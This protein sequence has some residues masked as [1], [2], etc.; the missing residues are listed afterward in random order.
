M[1]TTNPADCSFKETLCNFFM[2]IKLLGNHYFAW[3]TRS[4]EN[5]D[6]SISIWW[7]QPETAL[8]TLP[9]APRACLLLEVSRD[10]GAERDSFH[11]VG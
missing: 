3:L 7:Q 10:T 8:A 9:V 1:T 4:D 11:I 5:G 2:V 6:I